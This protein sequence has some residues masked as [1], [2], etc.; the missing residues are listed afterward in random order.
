M[1]R[2]APLAMAVLGLGAPGCAR[3]QD[4]ASQRALL[5]RLRAEHA[6]E[7]RRR[8]IDDSLRTAGIEVDTVRIGTLTV[9]RAP[10]VPPAL[11][12]GAA[13]A[14]RALD[15][16]FGGQTRTLGSVTFVLGISGAPPLVHH[17]PPGA[18]GLG[19]TAAA[20]S[21]A[22]ARTLASAAAGVISEHSDAA[23]REWLGG[24]LS[25]SPEPPHVLTEAY[26]EL[27]TE[28]WTVVRRCHAGD[29]DGC[30][31]MLGLVA[32]EDYL[33]Q[34]YDDEDRRH[35][36][37]A[38]SGATERWTAQHWAC[39]DGGSIDA[40]RALVRAGD[41]DLAHPPVTRAARATVVD[42][43]LALGGP[44]AYD[45]LMATAGHPIAQRLAAAAGVSSDSLLR[46][47]HARVM[48]ARPTAVTLDR[49]GAW[50]AFGWVLVAA[51][52]ALRSS[53]WR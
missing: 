16:R 7:E 49:T 18:R 2:L 1:R 42:L 39:V 51:A 17:P 41:G 50:T 44:G 22:L 25:P 29:L 15:S 28:P 21:G 27:A 3:A 52:L 11:P 5:A 38:E 37:A 33:D 6:R 13:G 36:V 19:I 10:G 32:D 43:T 45:R 48:A 9:L 24:G 26:V 46:S 40:C 30:R 14:W 23:F 8:R 34:W 47:W 4:A 31:R 53:R 12:A 20:D 35:L